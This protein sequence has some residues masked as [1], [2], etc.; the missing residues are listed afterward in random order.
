MKK[1]KEAFWKCGH[2]KNDLHRLETD[3]ETKMKTKTF[4]DDEKKYEAYKTFCS[5][6]LMKLFIYKPI[7]Q[8][9]AYSMEEIKSYV[10]DEMD[11]LNE[12]YNE[13]ATAFHTAQSR[14]ADIPA[15]IETSTKDTS[16]LTE[17]KHT[18]LELKVEEQ[19]TMLNSKIDNMMAMIQNQNMQVERKQQHYNHY[20]NRPMSWR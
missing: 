16:G 20:Q 12:H 13:L 9:K 11:D 6:E 17:S 1:A 5:K 4:T 3:W 14:A 8:A 15:T 10:R 7:A 2:D 19:N 18:A